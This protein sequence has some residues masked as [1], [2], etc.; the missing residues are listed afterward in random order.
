MQQH[1]PFPVHD[2]G[3]SRDPSQSVTDIDSE[4]S[5]YVA[6][7]RGYFGRENPHGAVRKGRLAGK[8]PGTTAAG[9]PQN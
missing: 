4:I 3:S 1:Y 6:A 8:Y 7:Y 5:R 2:T 9:K